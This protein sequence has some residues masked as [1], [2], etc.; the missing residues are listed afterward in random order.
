MKPYTS[1]TR[2]LELQMALRKAGD[3]WATQAL[4]VLFR[5]VWRD[6]DLARCQDSHNQCEA[7]REYVSGVTV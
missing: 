1:T 5:D 3:F 4:R 2:R 7:M 6:G